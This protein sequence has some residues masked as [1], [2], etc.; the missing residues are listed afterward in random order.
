M[1]RRQEPPEY[2]QSKSEHT[3]SLNDS[4]IQPAFTEQSAMNHSVR[5]TRHSDDHDR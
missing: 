3:L 5:H 4:L 2:K 1:R